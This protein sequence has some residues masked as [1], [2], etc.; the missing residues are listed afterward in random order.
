MKTAV[1][2]S[3]ERAISTSEIRFECPKYVEVHEYF[4]CNL[5]VGSADMVSGKIAW[6]GQSF[7]E[8]TLPSM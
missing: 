8:F 7:Q 5:S 3:I 1:Q 6:E 2:V 4:S